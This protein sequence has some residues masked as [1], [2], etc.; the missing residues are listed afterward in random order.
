MA[1]AQV[2]RFYEDHYVAS[3]MQ[4]CVLGSDSLDV[5]E[6]CV[7]SHFGGLRTG[8][9]PSA[10]ATAPDAADEPQSTAAPI[11]NGHSSSGDRLRHRPRRPPPTTS[12]TAH[13]G[14]IAH[15]GA[16]YGVAGPFSEAQRGAL[17]RATPVRDT[18]LLRLMWTVAPQRTFA[19]SKAMQLLSSILGFDGAG[20]LSWLLTQRLSPPLATSVS[21]GPLYTMSDTTI[22]GIS[23]TLT[24]QVRSPRISPNLPP[25]PPISA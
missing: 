22:F 7:A 16:P 1:P 21:T 23:L 4:L 6:E 18:R 17:L 12:V 5:L 15:D 24:P 9:A 19:E 11:A 25:S 3:S 20:G 14:A 2:R 13:D 8:T 10:L